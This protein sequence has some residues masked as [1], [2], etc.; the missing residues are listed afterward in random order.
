MKQS[1]FL[2]LGPIA[3]ATACAYT[4]VIF[5]PKNTCT[6]NK[7]TNNKLTEELCEKKR[8]CMRA[9]ANKLQEQLVVKHY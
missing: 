2:L 1:V 6:N 5:L 4:S 8:E 9:H 7:L 3:T